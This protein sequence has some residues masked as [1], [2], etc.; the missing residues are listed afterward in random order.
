MHLG[1]MYAALVASGSIESGGRPVSKQ[2]PRAN[3]RD[4]P[5]SPV[6]G[7]IVLDRPLN[8]PGLEGAEEAPVPEPIAAIAS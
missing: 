1:L 6:A 3:D 2:D 5:G 7:A 4:R 8:S